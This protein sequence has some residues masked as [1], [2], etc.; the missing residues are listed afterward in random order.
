M[1]EK[2][3]SRSINL[4]SFKGQKRGRTSPVSDDK[5]KQISSFNKAIVIPLFQRGGRRPGC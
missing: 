3:L 4:R 5:P 1:E 2:A